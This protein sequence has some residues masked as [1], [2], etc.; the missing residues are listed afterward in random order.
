MKISLNAHR[1]TCN[2]PRT[3]KEMAYISFGSFFADF[4]Y[5]FHY[6]T[7][8]I[9]CTRRIISTNKVVV[10]PFFRRIHAI[11]VKWY[12]NEGEIPIC[13]RETKTHFLT[14]IFQ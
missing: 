6:P 8:P 10:I 11:W 13:L 4:T 1:Q 14:D 7:Y 5:L 12:D 2:Q 9:F 3:I